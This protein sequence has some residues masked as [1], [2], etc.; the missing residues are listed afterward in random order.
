[1][2]VVFLFNHKKDRVSIK[3]EI[4]RARTRKP[5]EEEKE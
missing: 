4:K 5:E 2:T 1:M 3:Y